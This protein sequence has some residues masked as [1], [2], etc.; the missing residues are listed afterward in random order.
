MR[1]T[2]ALLA[3][4]FLLAA[5]APFTAT[6]DRDGGSVVITVEA[7]SEG[8]DLVGVTIIGTTL[9]TVDPRCGA[10]EDA[11]S[12]N[13]GNMPADTMTR[14]VVIGADV[15]CIASGYVGGGL[16]DYRVVRCRVGG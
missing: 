9:S 11:L 3:V 1:R 16:T 2:L 6:L 5:C 4:T 13:V 14:I 12:C 15:S 8:V 10:I 7:G